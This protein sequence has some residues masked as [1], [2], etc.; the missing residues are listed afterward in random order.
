MY[1]RLFHGTIYYIGILE[2]NA[3]VI[4][5]NIM[6]QQHWRLA[7]DLTNK[8][9]YISLLQPQYRYTYEIAG[10]FGDDPN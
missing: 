9:S 10:S 6:G 8:A 5:I 2:K 1:P 7:F 4:I 3:G